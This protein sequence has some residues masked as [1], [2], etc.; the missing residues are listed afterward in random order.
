MQ[1]QEQAE[2]QYNQQ[3]IQQNQRT[4]EQNRQNTGRLRHTEY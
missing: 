4:I 2:Y 1:G 3:Q